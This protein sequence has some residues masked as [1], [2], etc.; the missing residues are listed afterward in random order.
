MEHLSVVI[1]ILVYMERLSLYKD[2]S[3]YGT[4]VIYIMILVYMEHLS[5]V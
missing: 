1:R 2:T 5:F 4:P 3:V